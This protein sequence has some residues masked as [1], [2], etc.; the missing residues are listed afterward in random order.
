MLY[1]LTT[2]FSNRLKTGLVLMLLLS[3]ATLNNASHVQRDAAAVDLNTTLFIALARDAKITRQ[4]V[5]TVKDHY[6]NPAHFV[7]YIIRRPQ[8]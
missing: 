4:G 6:G 1:F 7:K 5:L 8:T 3:G 2:V